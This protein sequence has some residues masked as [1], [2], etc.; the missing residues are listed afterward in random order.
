MLGLSTDYEILFWIVWLFLTFIG[1]IV[2]MNFIIAKVGDSYSTC[3][4]LKD[5]QT[6]WVRLEMIVERESFMS[7][8][9]LENSEW[10]PKFIIY[11]QDS[12]DVNDDDM[13]TKLH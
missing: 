5:E 12:Q 9:E 6:A 7:D 2:L 10:F 1:Q 13:L 3:M 8:K 4:E 11:G